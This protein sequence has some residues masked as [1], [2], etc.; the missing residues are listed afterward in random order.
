MAE[1]QI[2]CVVNRTDRLLSY[3]KG[4]SQRTLTPG[5][6]HIPATHVRFALTQNVLMGSE[7]PLNPMQF[8]SLIG[9]KGNEKKYPCTPIVFA[10]DEARKPVAMFE[11]PNGE[12]MTVFLKSE[13][14]D[15]SKLPNKKARQA[16]EEDADVIIS[17]YN[18]TDMG[19]VAVDM[20]PGSPVDSMFAGN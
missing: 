12:T 9:V 4:G 13:R 15:R 8:M 10:M 19:P 18:I 11:G 14:F 6:N 2:V 17:R 3:T 1:S 7:N 16:V 5:E 20:T